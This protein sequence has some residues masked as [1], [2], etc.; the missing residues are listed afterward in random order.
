MQLV[1]SAIAGAICWYWG[2]WYGRREIQK[3]YDKIIPLIR[4][5]ARNGWR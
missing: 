1:A 5:E 3:R 2:Y 4:R